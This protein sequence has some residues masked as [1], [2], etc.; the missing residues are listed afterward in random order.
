VLNFFEC[1]F[2]DI[3]SNQQ[4]FACGFTGVFDDNSK[5]TLIFVFSESLG[6]MAPSCPTPCM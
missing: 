3:Q 5:T 4:E 2:P 6:D 1:T